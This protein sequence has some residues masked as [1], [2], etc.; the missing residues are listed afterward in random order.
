[1][2][3]ASEGPDPITPGKIVIVYGS[4]LEGADIFSNGIAAPIL[5]RSAAQIA[6]SRWQNHTQLTGQY[7]LRESILLDGSDW[8]LEHAQR[9]SGECLPS[10]RA[11]YSHLLRNGR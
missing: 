5:Y 1:M 6:D 4:G 7:S 11:E 2:D 10:C 9:S 3:A 8:A